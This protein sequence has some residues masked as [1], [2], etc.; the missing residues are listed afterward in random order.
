MLVLTL[1]TDSIEVIT[2][3]GADIAVVANYIDRDQTS[4]DVGLADRK[5][6]KPLT[7]TTTTIVSAPSGS[8]AT[9]R[10]V[11]SI[12][13]RNLDTTLSN[14]LTIQLNA[15]SVLYELYKCTL[16]AGESL[17]YVDGVGFFK[18]TDTTRNDITRVVSPSDSVHATA[19]TFADITGLTCPMLSGVSYSFLAHL[20]HISNA[21]TTGAQFGVNIGAAPTTLRVATIDTVTGSTTASVHSA[22]SVTAR[23]TAITAQTTGSAAVTLAIISGEIT[24]SADGT[25]AMRATSEVTVAAGLTVKVGSWLRVWKNVNA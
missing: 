5:V 19:A 23:D 3:S 16:L 6:S 12:F 15:N 11:K 4:G 25:F 10:N 22:G 24:P 7:A 17:Q 20:F 8:P 2:S 21:T 14:D 1:T 18:F 9:T 13:M